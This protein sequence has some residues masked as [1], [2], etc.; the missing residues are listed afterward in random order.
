[1]HSPVS[2]LFPKFHALLAASHIENQVCFHKYFS[3]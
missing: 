3:Y 1:M 2:K